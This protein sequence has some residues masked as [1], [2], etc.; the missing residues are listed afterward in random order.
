MNL[1]KKEAWKIDYL[2]KIDGFFSSFPP[3]IKTR[4][5]F[6][7]RREKF[8]SNLEENFMTFLDSF[9]S[10]KCKNSIPLGWVMKNY[11]L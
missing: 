9:S 6:S 10:N 7:A 5:I 3:V 11:E 2:N 8:P 1:K 4:N